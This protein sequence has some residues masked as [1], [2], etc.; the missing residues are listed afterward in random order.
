VLQYNEENYRYVQRSMA[1][2]QA[3]DAKAMEAQ[4]KE[5]VKAERAK[6]ARF[7]RI[8]SVL[9]LSQPE[10]SDMRNTNLFALAKNTEASNFHRKEQELIFKEI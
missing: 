4:R 6:K 2:Q 1:A 10:Y 5:A 8:S 9:D 3:R 7:D